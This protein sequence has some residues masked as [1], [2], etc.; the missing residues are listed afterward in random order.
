[1]TTYL[2]NGRRGPN[3]GEK[4]TLGG[5]VVTCIFV[6]GDDKGPMASDRVFAEFSPHDKDLERA[7]IAHGPF[8]Y[9][10]DE[11]DVPFKGWF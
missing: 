6:H 5:T 2:N 7:F 4:V 11:H 10:T 8:D 1:M 9:I 3:V